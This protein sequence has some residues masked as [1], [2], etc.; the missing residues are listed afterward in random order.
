[1]FKHPY[2]KT[3]INNFVVFCIP[4]TGSYGLVSRLDSTP[5][6]ACYGEIF[7]REYIEID[8]EIKKS[9]LINSIEER[10]DNPYAYID[11]IKS[12]NPD[13]HFGFKLFFQHV[14]RIPKLN[15]ILKNKDWKRVLLL[16]DPIEVYASNVRAAKT[17]IWTYST[18]DK[19]T[20]D[21]LNAKITFDQKDFDKFMSHY[22]NYID[23]C[24]ELSKLPNTFVIHQ[25]EINNKNVIN[26]LLS[27]LGSKYTS[28]STCSK[29]KKQFTKKFKD[30][31]N[32][33]DDVDK[34]LKQHKIKNIIP[35]TYQT[36]TIEK[37]DIT[38][39]DTDSPLSR[40]I[41]FIVRGLR[42]K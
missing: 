40:I 31:F 13:K 24:S 4:R 3:M 41:D 8:E 5:D 22:G 16:R 35:S 6:I 19:I 14:N 30:G 7:K 9:L 37:I 11:E 10:D 38:K 34:Y 1:M 27:F 17:G 39:S 25:N 2:E 21:K 33:W 36:L 18:N 32:N 20:P 29:Y 12:Y 15:S 23:I 26:L 28:T 42:R